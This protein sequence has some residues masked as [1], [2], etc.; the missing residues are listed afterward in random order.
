MYRCLWGLLLDNDASFYLDKIIR[1]GWRGS[2]FAYPSVTVAI[3]LALDCHYRLTSAPH[4][5]LG[6]EVKAW[7]PLNYKHL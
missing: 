5:D 3:Q 4:F 7:K 6:W 1:R 2:E